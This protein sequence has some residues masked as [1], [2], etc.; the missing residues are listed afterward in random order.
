MSLD[1]LWKTIKEIIGTPIQHPKQYVLILLC[2]LI[3]VIFLPV[4]QDVDDWS[5]NTAGM[6]DDML[7]MYDNENRVYPPWGL[8]LLIPFY[9]MHI[10]GARFLSVLIAACLVK[11]QRLP[12]YTF[13]LILFSPYFLYTMYLS[14]MDILVI[15]FPLLLWDYAERKKWQWVG[16]GSSL[17]L[18][19]LKPQTTFLMLIY[20]L[21]NQRKQWK[22]L[23]LPLSVV[24]MITV[25][26][27]LIGSPPL[28][29]QWIHNITHPSQ[30]NQIYWT[31]NN[32]SL[33]NHLSVPISIMILG[34][35]TMIVVL[36]FYSRK[37]SW[38]KTQITAG[39]LMISMLLSPYTSRQSVTAGLVFVPSTTSLLLQYGLLP[40]MMVIPDHER[41]YES[42][43]ILCVF[44]VS[45]LFSNAKENKHNT[46]M[47][48]HEP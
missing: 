28:I 10:E 16:R 45:V 33:S 47:N 8:I 24:A 5:L 25:P 21:W 15:V 3:L 17:S 37:Q 30:Q 46:E 38:Q 7:Q 36:I 43:I 6:W 1:S 35:I 22:S 9:L 20:L 27:S 44:T 4:Q 23:L 14:N 29:M 42:L 39:L 31:E 18:L 48:S 19:L 2:A 40:L 26:V 41:S 34:L 11:K 12:F 32:I 13:F